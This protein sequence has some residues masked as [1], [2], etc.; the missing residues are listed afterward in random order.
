MI[1][2]KTDMQLATMHLLEA[3]K[4][5]K[6]NDVDEVASTV[7]QIGMSMISGIK[8]IERE[9]DIIERAKYNITDIEYDDIMNKLESID[10]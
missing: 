9:E 5:L 2:Y 10:V 1:E 6:K 7:A 4:I 8:E 3:A